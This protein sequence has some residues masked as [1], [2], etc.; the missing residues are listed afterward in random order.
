LPCTF[1]HNITSEGDL[2]DA[3]ARLNQFLHKD[4]GKDTPNAGK[5][6]NIKIAK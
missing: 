5:S 1:S 4:T 6:Q 3:A 2:K